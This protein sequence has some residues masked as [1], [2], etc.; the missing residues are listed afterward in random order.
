MLIQISEGEA[1]DRL[2]ILEIKYNRICNPL[3]MTEIQ[4][5]IYSLSDIYPLKEKYILYYKLLIFINSV[6][7]DKTNYAKETIEINSKYGENAYE[8]FEHNQQRFRIKNSINYS[9]NSNVKEQKSYLKKQITF[10]IKSNQSVE[11]ILHLLSY[12][13]ITY[14]HVEIFQN[15]YLLIYNDLIRNFLPSLSIVNYTKNLIINDFDIVM[16]ETYHSEL[17]TIISSIIH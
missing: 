8:I 14:D 5:E 13:L 7:W 11:K 12:L 6:I 17:H 16:P 4:K 9:E 15:D 2:S 3:Q 10:A 1:L